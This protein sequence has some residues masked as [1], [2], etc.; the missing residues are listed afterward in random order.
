MISLIWKCCHRYCMV[1]LFLP[2]LVLRMS[3][4]SLSFLCKCFP[5]QAV[6][7]YG[8]N[9]GPFLLVEE[10]VSQLSAERP[11]FSND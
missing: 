5:V 11:A 10:F 4:Q 2:H 6:L 7:S 3:L 8:L 1:I 9:E